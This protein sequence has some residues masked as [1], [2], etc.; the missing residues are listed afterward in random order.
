MSC[1]LQKKIS[2]TKFLN[3]NYVN[4]KIT[5]CLL[6]RQAIFDVLKQSSLYNHTINKEKDILKTIYSFII[7]TNIDTNKNIIEKSPI[8]FLENSCFIINEET[9]N[10]VMIIREIF[11]ICERNNIK[12]WIEIEVND[13]I[14]IYKDE[15]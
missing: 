8:S 7:N 9:T 4:S 12:L 13:D 3:F 1:I 15:D 2:K 10:E 5:K 11:N 6:R 14:L